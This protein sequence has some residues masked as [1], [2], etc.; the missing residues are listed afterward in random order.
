MSETTGAPDG[1]FPDARHDHGDCVAEALR[2]AEGLCAE[3]GA[4]LTELRRFRPLA[5][6]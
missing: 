2:A 1:A 6:K 5:G 4:R 3:S